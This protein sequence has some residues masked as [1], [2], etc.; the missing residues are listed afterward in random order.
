M[1]TKRRPRKPPVSRAWAWAIEDY[2]HNLT[3]AGLSA[4]TVRLRHDQLTSMARDI[5]YE[6]DAVTGPLL[7]DWLGRQSWS[8]EY[9]RSYRTAT[10]SFF[11][12]AYKT[13]LVPVYFGD[14]LPKVRNAKGVPRPAPDD[15]WRTAFENADPRLRL[16]LRLAGEAGLRRGEVAQVNTRDVFLTRGAAQLLVHGKGDRKRTV[17]I[18]DD[19]AEAIRRGAAGHTPGMPASGWLFPPMFSAAAT[20]LPRM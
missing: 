2:L 7:I 11:S 10:R 4:A 15:V 20:C 17:P 12:W 14:E 13:G 16:M 3:A 1:S 6:P 9:R 19:L 8:L 18:S 5:G